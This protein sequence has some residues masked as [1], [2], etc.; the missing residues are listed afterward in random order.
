MPYHEYYKLFIPESKLYIL[1]LLLLLYHSLV[2]T[3]LKEILFKYYQSH[4]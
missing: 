4:C 2:I 3:I 1:L